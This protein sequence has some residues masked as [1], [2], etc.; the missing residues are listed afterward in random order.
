[1]YFLPRSVIEFTVIFQN[2]IL[3]GMPFL[4]ILGKKDKIKRRKPRS[5]VA[6]TI[7]NKHYGALKDR[8]CKTT[9]YVWEPVLL[10]S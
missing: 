7:L 2:D 3:P 10:V 5:G 4:Y 9:V 8:L 6:S 1:M